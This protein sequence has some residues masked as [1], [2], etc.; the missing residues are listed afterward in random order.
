MVSKSLRV[1]AASAGFVSLLLIS[2]PVFAQSPA[3]TVTPGAKAT[4]AQVNVLSRLKTK[5][6][7]E[8]DRRIA[9]LNR[10]IN[11]I[12]RV[13]RL[14]DS[15]KSDLK[16]QVQTE[17]TG[18]TTL[19]TKIDGDTDV[20][21][22]R[23]DVQSIVKSYRIY[24]LFIPKIYIIVH[25]D[26]L[27]NIADDMGAISVLLQTRIDEAKAAGH[28]TTAMQNL[29]T[30]RT[31]KLA[32][33]KTQAQKAIDA[34]LPLTP[35]GFPANKATLQ[36]ARTMLQTARADLRMAHK[37]AQDIRRLLSAVGIKT[38]AKLTPIATVTT[39]PTPTP[40]P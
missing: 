2:S 11:L 9:G 1:I 24:A 14:T 36:S 5:A 39:T 6:D 7:K 35:D 30:D 31:N 25:A 27:T 8:I 18:L 32:D 38:N 15:Q 22:L 13:K 37:D 16:T 20:A 28:D 34:V 19:K 3:V 17:I 21:T 40:T 12:D 10:L 29:M 4:A 26:R 33:A 23:T